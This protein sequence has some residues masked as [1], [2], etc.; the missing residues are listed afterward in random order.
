MRNIIDGV[1]RFQ[2]DV[3]PEYR[4]EFKK[5]AGSQHPGTLLI[6]CADSRIVPSMITQTGPG[7]LFICRNA[8]NIVPPYGEVAGG[9]SATIEY[10]VAVLAVQSIVVC[11]HSDC[12]AMRAALDLSKVAA[13]PAVSSWLS[14]TASAVAITVQ[15]CTDGDAMARLRAVTEENVL[16]QMQHLTTH[17]TVAAALE[18]SA[19]EVHGWIYDI[20]SAA[21][22]AYDP[23]RKRFEPVDA[24]ATPA[25]SQSKRWLARR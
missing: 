3:F 10:A 23:E 4:E 24:D 20:E 13:L 2:K 16:L 6:T 8:G 12:G 18:R 25:I 14:H 17:P 22:L 9:V 19:L 11:G 15:T 1:H 7:A 21:V 5:L